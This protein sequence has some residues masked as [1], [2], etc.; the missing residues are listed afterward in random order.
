MADSSNAA[1]GYNKIAPF[2]NEHLASEQWIR[3][4]LWSCYLSYY[5][6]GDHVLDVGCGTGIDS[7]FLAEQGINV[8]AIDISSEMIA[9]LKKSATSLNVGKMIDAK[10]LDITQLPFLLPMQ[11]DGIISAFAGLNMVPDLFSFA[12]NAATLLK[13]G[14]HMILH[15]LNQ[16]PA[17]Q[18]LRTFLKGKF[19]EAMNPPYQKNVLIGETSVAHFLYH[20]DTVFNIY[21]ASRF[22][23]NYRGGIVFLFPRKLISLLP[24]P[25]KK[26][27]GKIEWS[28]GQYKPFLSMGDFFILDIVKK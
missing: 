7:I 19:R 1:S 18:R 3:D 20:A 9:Q 26:I 24:K 12:D 22:Q 11:F 28:I 21:F 27:Y 16:K 4:L 8:T 2:Y 13:P 14:G 6:A 17:W 5:K 15:M 23:L 25:V 10:I